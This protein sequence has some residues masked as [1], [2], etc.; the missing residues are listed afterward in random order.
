MSENITYRKMK[1]RFCEEFA[2]F[3]PNYGEVVFAIMG[4]HKKMQIYESP[5]HVFQ[6]SWFGN[7]PQL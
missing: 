6:I 3:V 5:F 4:R 7:I 1:I 2:N